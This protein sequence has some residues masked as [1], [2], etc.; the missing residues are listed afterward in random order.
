MCRNLIV[1][2]VMFALATTSYGFERVVGDWED[3][4]LEGWDNCPTWYAESNATLTPG[5][6]VGVTLNTGS[7]EIAGIPLGDATYLG[8]RVDGYDTDG[9]PIFA[10]NYDRQ[11]PDCWWFL[12][13]DHGTAEALCQAKYPG[14]FG[15]A[16]FKMDLTGIPTGATI[17][18]FIHF[19][20]NGINYA[21]TDKS[22]TPD[23][24]GNL[25]MVFDYINDLT[26][27]NTD[28][29]THPTYYDTDYVDEVWS[30][31]GSWTWDGLKV[32]DLVNVN[33]WNPEWYQ[34]CISMESPGLGTLGTS[35]TT[36]FADY[37]RFETP[38]P[39]TIALLGLGG[40][41]LIRRKR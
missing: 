24:A 16:V 15:Q 38:E 11:Y 23:G 25:A 21:K 2:A 7:L 1:M 28:H 4:N 13:G 8:T 27:D 37:A 18:A 22:F 6:T 14:L 34:L 29:P 35:T 39:T 32:P 40:L 3:G 9:L 41:A 31:V 20:G 19:G 36:L 17:R 30:D 12:R 26:T 5:A 33:T 10:D